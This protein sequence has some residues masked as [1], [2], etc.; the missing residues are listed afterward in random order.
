MT[1]APTRTRLF[2]WAVP[3]AAVAVV[4][5]A[6]TGVLTA[7]ADPPLPPKTAAQLLVDLQ[8]AQVRRAVRHGGAGL[9]PGAA[10]AADQRAGRRQH[11][12]A[13]AADRLAHAAGL[14]RGGGQAAARAARP[15]RRDRRGAQ[16][17]GRLAVVQRVQLGHP[18]PAAGRQGRQ[19]ERRRCRA[20]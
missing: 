3:V 19:G 10:R 6:A 16:R 8:G 2:R 17:A 11:V 4:G 9:R 12:A 18:L 1:S 13:L 15:A 7:E 20:R 14:V 5:V